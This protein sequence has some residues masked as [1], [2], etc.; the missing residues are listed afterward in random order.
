V[1]SFRTSH[2]DS[3]VEIPAVPKSCGA[4]AMVFVRSLHALFFVLLI[5][6]NLIAKSFWV[7]TS[8]VTPKFG[9]SECRVIVS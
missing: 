8:H 9:F 6:D 7:R 2:H 3:K 5:L 4:G 1:F